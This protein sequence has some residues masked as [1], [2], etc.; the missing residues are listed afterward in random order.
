M[1]FWQDGWCGNRPLQLTFSRLYGIYTDGEASIE[2]PLTRLG[3]GERRSW[4]V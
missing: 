4:D 3:A 1:R 2:S